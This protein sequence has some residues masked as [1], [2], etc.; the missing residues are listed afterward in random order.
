M[1]RYVD[2]TFYKEV[3][4]GNFT[5]K[6]FNLYEYKAR[7]FID[8]ITFNR[9]NESNLTEDVK[10]AVCI[11]LEKI[12][13]LEIEGIKTSE[14]VGKHSVSFFVP[15]SSSIEKILYKEAVTYL[16]SNLLYRGVR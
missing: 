9:I 12:K 4:E 14:T 5:L 15:Q 13:S 10:I 1:N 11:L 7:K 8:K 2:Y 16:P 6:D 3:F